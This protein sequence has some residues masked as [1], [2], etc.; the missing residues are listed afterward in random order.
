MCRFMH[1]WTFAAI[2]PMKWIQSRQLVECDGASQN[3]S[4]RAVVTL[5]GCN[6]CLTSHHVVS[7]DK[8]SESF[9]SHKNARMN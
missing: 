7:K 3:P 4:C 1:P 6:V 2:T 9:T 8:R 5:L